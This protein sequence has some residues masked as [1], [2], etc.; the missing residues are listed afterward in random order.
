MDGVR[1]LTPI[2]AIEEMITTYQDVNGPIEEYNAD[3][4]SSVYASHV[5]KNR[6]FIIRKG[7]SNWTAASWSV[8]Y[9]Q[10]KMYGKPVNVAETPVGSVLHATLV[11]AALIPDLETQIQ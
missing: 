7:C 3:P 9:L 4:S 6:P 2:E 11:N 1:V 5:A 8:R 10:E